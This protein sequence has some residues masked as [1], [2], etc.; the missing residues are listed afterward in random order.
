MFSK[1]NLLGKFYFNAGSKLYL[2]E[3][4][5]LSAVHRH[6]ALHQRKTEP[7]AARLP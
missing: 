3:Y 4:A 2:A 5:E 1:C 7:N 6:Y